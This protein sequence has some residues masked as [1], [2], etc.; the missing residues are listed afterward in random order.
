MG[1]VIA[2]ASFSQ[3]ESLKERLVDEAALL[4]EEAKLLPPGPVRDATIRAARQTRIAACLNDW[5]N[6]P[7]LQAPT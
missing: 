5:A 6:S 4:R 7:G 3:S 2:M 1:M